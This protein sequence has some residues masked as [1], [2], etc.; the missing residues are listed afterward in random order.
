MEVDGLERGAKTPGKTG[1]SEEGD[2]E[3]DV[4]DAKTSD[5]AS[6]VESLSPEDRAKLAAM[7]KGE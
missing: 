5:L 2:V 7:L 4:I 1:N 6:L 3:S